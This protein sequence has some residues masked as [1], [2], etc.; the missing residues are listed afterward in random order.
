MIGTQIGRYRITDELGRGGMGVVYRATQVTLNRTVAVKMLFPHLASSG[1][2]LERFRREAETLARL[3]HEN[4][5]RIFDIEEYE[6]THC[7]IMEYVGGPS[8]SAVLARERRLSPRRARDI[9]ADVAAALCAAHRQGIIHRDIKPDNILFNAEGRP[10]LTDFGIARI[11]HAAQATRTG[12]MIGTPWY[13]SPEQAAGRPVTPASDLYSL[14]VVLFEMLAGRVPFEGSDALAIA[15]KHL[16]EAPPPLRPLAPEAGAEL[17][18]LVARTLAKESTRRHPSAAELREALLATLL[19]SPESKPPQPAPFAEAQGACP[20]C[21]HELHA[22]F[23]TCPGCGRTIRQRCARCERL[24]DPLSP[25]CPYCRTPAT[26]VRITGE[27]ASRTPAG[28]PAT[29]RL[30]AAGQWRRAQS[31]AVSLVRDLSPAMQLGVGALV[32]LVL[33]LAGFGLAARR[34]RGLASD[35]LFTSGG[36]TRERSAL[37]ER[38]RNRPLTAAEIAAISRAAGDSLAGE[39]VV[40]GR[41]PRTVAER[42]PAAAAEGV[43]RAGEESGELAPPPAPPVAGGANVFDEAAARDEIL[44]IIERQHRATETGDVELLLQ[45]VAPERH[46]EVRKSFGEMHASAREIKSE[47]TRI[48]ISFRPGSRVAVEFHA[49]LTGKRISDGR[50]V[51]IYNGQVTWVLERRDEDWLIVDL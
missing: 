24:Y 21:G 39:E 4:I 44:E 35:D 41:V 7:I 37:V 3:D 1:E 48:E 9:A 18:D 29:P 23:L 47:I 51:T 11:A 45:D 17:C 26:P 31:R 25:E 27:T 10:K 20:E 13:M 19:A 32:V 15:L 40:P 42:E 2:Y 22:N 46:P 49:R 38:S 6:D 16:N 8:L 5:V 30:S 33:A 50:A 14:G 43:S 36:S 28:S 34:D 12:V